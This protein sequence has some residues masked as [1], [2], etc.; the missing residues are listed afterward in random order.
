M[1]S[2]KAKRRNRDVMSA[3]N[4]EALRSHGA[5]RLKGAISDCWVE[6]LRKGIARN[7]K[8]PSPLFKGTVGDDESRGYLFDIW[9]RQKIP[10]FD[11]FLR[12]SGMAKLAA[13]C[14]GVPQARLMLD[15]WFS[16]PAGTL[17]RTHR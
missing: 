1:E 17:E 12:N 9:T 3:T 10:E 15:A 14:L 2:A 6:Q 16:K 13:E 4:L 7:I 11:A 5:I 8:D